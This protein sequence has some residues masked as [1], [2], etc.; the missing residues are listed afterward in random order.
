MTADAR[1]AI[2]AARQAFIV[3]RLVVDWWTMSELAAQG[4]VSQGAIWT[5]VKRISA[6]QIVFRRR[7]T[8]APHLPFEYR[9]YPEAINVT[10]AIATPTKRSRG[11]RRPR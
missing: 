1:R 4:N 7:R 3:R 11:A 9:S 8:S 5:I 2:E 6:R 10:A